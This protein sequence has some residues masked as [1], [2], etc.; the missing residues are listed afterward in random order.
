MQ[1]TERAISSPIGLSQ[2][3]PP[4]TVT[5]SGFLALIRRASANEPTLWLNIEV[6]P[7]RSASSSRYL[8]ISWSRSFAMS[9]PR[10]RSRAR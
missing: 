3:A 10:A 1:S 2:L 9:R 4:I 6:K 5:M 8:S 7:T